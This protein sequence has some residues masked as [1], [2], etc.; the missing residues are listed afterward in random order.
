MANTGIS[1]AVQYGI[2][3]NVSVMVP[4]PS[5][6][7]GIPLLKQNRNL[8]ANI[9]LHVVLNSEWDPTEGGDTKWGPVAADV[10]TLVDDNGWFTQNPNVL[11][12][13]GFSLDEAEREIRAQ[14]AKLADAGLKPDYIDEHM[15]V[16]WLPG[17]RDRIEAVAADYGLIYRPE[18]PFVPAG[19]QFWDTLDGDEPALCVT[20][21]AWPDNVIES[22]IHDGIEPGQVANE[23]LADYNFLTDDSVRDRIATLEIQSITYRDL[24]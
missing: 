13:R 18:L 10:P 15:G 23:R 22:W 7:M 12:Q 14:Y 8:G 16:G 9:G 21:P 1:A 19:D 11:H 20:H 4:G 24:A 17:L 2:L 6:E 3:R 5:F